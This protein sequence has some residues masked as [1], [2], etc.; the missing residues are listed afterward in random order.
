MK[1][2]RFTEDQIIGVLKEHEAGMKTADLCRKHGISEATFYNWK[3]KYGGMVMGLFRATSPAQ[4]WRTRRDS[5]SRPLPPEGPRVFHS[6]PLH[7]ASGCAIRSLPP[8]R[9]PAGS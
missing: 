6:P 7:P 3:A 9:L 4:H 1:R 8:R 2:S 5:N